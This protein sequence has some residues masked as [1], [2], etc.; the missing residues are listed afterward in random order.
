MLR[1]REEA[2][3]QRYAN[4]IWMPFFDQLAAF[5]KALRGD[6]TGAIELGRWTIADQLAIGITV[7]AGPGTALLVE[8]LL[9]RSAP[10]DLEEAEAAIERLSAQ[11]IEPGFIPY[12]LP[13]LRLRALVAEARGD[14]AGYLDYRDRY[15]EMAHRVDFKPHIAMAEAMP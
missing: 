7:S 14:N 5:A 13:L 3:G 11:P 8:S 6:V 15:R 2:R 10:G 4:P 12:E 9:R 1:L